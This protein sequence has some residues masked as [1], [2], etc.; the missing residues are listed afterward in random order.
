V[1]CNYDAPEIPD[2]GDG[3]VGVDCEE[4]QH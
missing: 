2:D 1:Y 3:G 4:A